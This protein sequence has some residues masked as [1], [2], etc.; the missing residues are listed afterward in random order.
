MGEA[1]QRLLDAAVTFFAEHGVSDLSM[2]QIAAELGTSHRMLIYHFGSKDGLL[3]E[4]VRTVE[5]QQRAVL[6]ELLADGALPPAEQAR[7]FWVRLLEPAALYG[8]LFFE[9]SG[10]ALQGRPHTAALREGLID[11]WLDPLT[12]LA[13]RAGVAPERARA[14]AR[15][16]LAAARGLLFDLLATG[17]REGVQD[18]VELLISLYD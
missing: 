5:A 3:S 9:L 13:L 11:M 10:Q 4:V 8:R 7:R 18:A 15:L 17:D 2:R 6:D 12:E 1:K 16:N 14:H